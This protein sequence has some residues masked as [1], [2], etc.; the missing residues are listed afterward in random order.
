MSIILY[1]CGKMTG[2]GRRIYR[3]F[4]ASEPSELS[5]EWETLS[6]TRWDSRTSIQYCPTNSTCMLCGL[7]T[8]LCSNTWICI[9]TRRGFF[10]FKF[11]FLV[12]EKVVE[13]NCTRVKLQSPIRLRGSS[14][15]WST[16]SLFVSSFIW[17]CWLSHFLQHSSVHKKVRIIEDSHVPES[18]FYVI[19]HF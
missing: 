17:S 9:R 13:A 11:P 14:T 4:Q 1:P 7:H 5:D 18:D 3:C 6:Q 8:C 12:S 15:A 16:W 10:F 2:T 19:L